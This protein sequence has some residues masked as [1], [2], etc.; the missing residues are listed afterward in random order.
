MVVEAEVRI[1]ECLLHLLLCSRSVSIS[2]L[3][4]RRVLPLRMWIAW[5]FTARIHQEEE[6]CLLGVLIDFRAVCL[7]GLR[8]IISTNK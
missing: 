6:D 7:D 8:S 3:F 2:Q 1:H 4:K 5:S